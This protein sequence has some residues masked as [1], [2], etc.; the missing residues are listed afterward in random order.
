VK[1]TSIICNYKT[2]KVNQIKQKA[3][4]N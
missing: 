2:A 1:E 4:V 3:H